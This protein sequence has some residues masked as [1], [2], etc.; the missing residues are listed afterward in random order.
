[1]RN[2]TKATLA[3]AAILASA[4]VI[5][6]GIRQE[7]GDISNVRV[8]VSPDSIGVVADT[9]M[10]YECHIGS[11]DYRRFP[12]VWCNDAEINVPKL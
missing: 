7:F 11:H 3:L 10:H 6:Y 8:E 2:E 9:E 4:G 12:H 5:G 1:M